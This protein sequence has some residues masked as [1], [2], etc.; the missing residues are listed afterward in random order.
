LNRREA[1]WLAAIVAFGFATRLAFGMH[2]PLEADEA[3]TAL[4]AHGILLGH[5]PVMESNA[6]YQG[7]LESYLMAPFIGVI[8]NNL[9]AVRVAMSFVGALYV[10]AMFGLG[11]SL[12]A[13]SRS[14]LLLA[15]CAAVFPLFEL[16][17]NMHARSGYAE[18]VVFEVLCLTLAIRLGWGDKGSRL[19]WWAGFGVLAGIAMWSYSL[20]AISLVVIAMALL[21]RA[22]ALGWTTFFRG[23]A[24]AF[25]AFV[26]GF[27]PWIAFNV[28][29][30]LG[31]LHS[32][33]KYQTGVMNS[34]AGLVGKELPVFIGTWGTCGD[35][36]VSSVFAWLLF[37]VVATAVIV[38]RRVQLG[39]L[40]RLQLTTLEPL[41][42]V[43]AVAPVA[44]LAVTVGRFNGIPCEPRYLLPFSIPAALA[45]ALALRIRFPQRWGM[46]LLAGAYAVIGTIT[47]AGKTTDSIAGVPGGGLVPADPT[48]GV[49]LLHDHHVE[50]VFG[51]YWLMRPVQYVDA[52]R[53]PV[54]IYGGWAG[55][56]DSQRAA[57]TA[58]HPSWLFATGDGH[59][60][61]LA[62]MMRSRGITAQTFA[63]S[64]YI[65]YANLSAPIRP[66]DLGLNN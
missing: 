57:E 65:L 36:T 59:A 4:T 61:I 55:F 27:S 1:L 12:F 6:H 20:V 22:P 30:G 53:I 40:V 26:L 66:A 32:I 18:M 2:L 41:D 11:R 25:G 23:A 50:A 17:W 29:H 51:Y 31:S 64:G 46:I 48:P 33:P 58:S 15:G 7:A 43:L 28:T 8:G 9:T 49:Q 45:A 63:G 35:H 60:Q 34:V 56:P 39:R 37:A 10:L 38:Q 21:C 52:G 19:R 54:G 16:T 3:T 5:F 62:A 44:L 42:M 24:V 13:N 14:A 47:A